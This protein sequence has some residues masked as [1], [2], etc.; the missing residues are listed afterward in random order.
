M[1]AFSIKAF[2]REARR[3]REFR[4]MGLYIVG[5]W[6]VLQIADLA[7]P[8]LG[9]DE[10]AIRYVWIGAILGLPV[11]LFFGWRYD[12]VDGQIIR[13]AASDPDADLSIQ[14]ADYV[15]L[16]T[17]GLII[18]A[19]AI[20]LL[21]EISKR[22]EVPTTQ[23]VFGD[24]DPNSIAVLPF[25]DLS[26]EG[27]QVYFTDG[28]SEEI[29][30]ALAHIPELRVISRSSSFSFRGRD[31]HMPTL[32]EQLGVNYVLEGS[33][34]KSGDDLRITA[35]LINARADE[36]IWSDNFD[37]KLENVFA[38]QEEISL[39]VVGALEKELGLQTDAR[40]RVYTTV[41]Q[42]AYEAFLL[43]R[44]LFTQDEEEAIHYFE[45]ATALDP[46]YARAHA[47]LAMAI[48]EAH[49]WGSGDLKREEALARSRLHAERAIALDPN[50][51]EAYVPI[52]FLLT[53][54]GK[55]EEAV[56]Q[57]RQAVRIN[58]NYADAYLWLG[59]HVG[60]YEGHY[61]ESLD[62]VENGLRLEP[63]SFRVRRRYVNML[64]NRGRL[65]DAVREMD[66]WAAINPRWHARRRGLLALRDGKTAD[67][68]FGNLDALD[69]DL[70]T[71][72]TS[73]AVSLAKIGLEEEALRLEVWHPLI[74][75]LIG[76]PEDALRFAAEDFA[77]EP[78]G[79][80]HDIHR[81]FAMALAGTG[82]YDRALPL[83]EETWEWAAGRV[84]GDG[85]P[86]SPLDAAALIVARR[87]A[88][89]HDSVGEVLEAMRKDVEYHRKGGI[90][91]L[92]Q[93]NWH[94]DFNDGLASY[95]SGERERGLALIARA[96][97]D[98]Y[99][100][101]SNVAYLQELYDDPGFER[102]RLA[103]EARKTRERQRFLTVVCNDNPYADIWQPLEE[104]CEGFFAN[105]RD[106]A[107]VLESSND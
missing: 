48:L 32:A 87:A 21:V 4:V 43:G 58:P 55:W 29:L 77:A 50:L 57:F 61:D 92:I 26:P 79:A 104:T 81:R 94:V 38:V 40:P 39:E 9:I 59:L 105:V 107:P 76:R 84:S 35:Q 27:D 78:V 80:D 7:F 82:D 14:R 49:Y 60:W 89:D 8:A 69:A 16:G 53:I 73:F 41:S 15:I 5:T 1:A 88:G 46:D 6:V 12:I 86:F 68:V 47:V 103:Q 67:A 97:R 19:T 18:V 34:R 13:S 31:V 17:L 44:H 65:A 66:K 91:G 100:V 22:T 83:L 28:I 45:K 85:D 101:W 102:I 11:A 42:E 64:V 10:S 71:S 33:V 20:G 54:Q 63:L 90:T 99:H 23:S 93:F 98:G 37:R 24:I 62:L 106:S 70:G 72:R 56:A 2:I 51:A 25:L 74:F 52:G 96:V 30:N 95:L 75:N 3:R 36:H